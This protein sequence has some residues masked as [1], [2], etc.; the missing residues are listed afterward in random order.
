MDYIEVNDCALKLLSKGSFAQAQKL[1]FENAK[2]NP[3][4][5]TY[6]NLGWYL[7]TEGLECKNGKVRNAEK[8]GMFYLS[9]AEKIK[10]TSVNLGNMASAMERQRDYIYCQTG[11]DHSDLCR[12]AYRYMDQAVK[13]KY[14]NEAE[15]DRLRFLYLCDS[16]NPEVLSGLKKLSAKFADADCIEFLLHVLCIHA[17]FQECLELIPQYQDHL[18]EMCLMS[19]YCLCG[20]FEKGADLCDRIYEKFVLTPDDT[21]MLADCLISSG[22]SEK[23]MKLKHALKE[24]VPTEN[25]K[26]AREICCRIDRIFESS[27]YRAKL[28]QG[29]QFR[30][31]FMALCGYFGCKLHA[32]PFF[33]KTSL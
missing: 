22:Q 10:Y 21:A 14:S 29:Y 18:D 15:Y 23:A 27:E 19:V 31:P 4:H 26:A 11:V 7:F 33:E 20:E 9:K 1:L 24:D 12:S 28:I 32:T 6:N 3:S 8:L 30:P 17:R 25:K 13:L 16:R 5:E 2:S